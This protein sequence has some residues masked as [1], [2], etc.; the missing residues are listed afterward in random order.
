MDNQNKNNQKNNKQG[1]GIIIIT[2]L[3]AAVIVLG[4][5]QFMEESTEDGR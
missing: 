1:F 3:I 5:Y 4:L 2:T